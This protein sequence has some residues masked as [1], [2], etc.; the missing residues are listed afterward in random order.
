MATETY[1]ITMKELSKDY[2]ALRKEL[3]NNMTS[4]TFDDYC[5]HYF[6]FLASEEA[7]EY[8]NL[9]NDDNELIEED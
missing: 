2:L 1:L 6:T 9:L 7:E 5:K 4:F 3:G 8:P